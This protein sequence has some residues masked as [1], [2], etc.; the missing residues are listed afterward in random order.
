MIKNIKI[1]KA[2]GRDGIPGEM[3]KYGEESLEEG[4]WNFCNKVWKGEGWPDK[5]ERRDYNTDS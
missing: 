5:L 3:W 2:T 1:G 4:I